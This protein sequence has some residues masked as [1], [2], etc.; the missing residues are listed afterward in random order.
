MGFSL[1]DEFSLDLT[2]KKK[3]KKKIERLE[4]FDDEDGKEDAGTYLP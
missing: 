3:K 4:D 2:K 1:D